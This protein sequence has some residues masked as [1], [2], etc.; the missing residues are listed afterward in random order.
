MAESSGSRRRPGPGKAFIDNSIK[1][2]LANFYRFQLVNPSSSSQEYE[3][4]PAKFDNIKLSFLLWAKTVPPNGLPIKISESANLT[5]RRTLDLLKNEDRLEEEFGL[6]KTYGDITRKGENCLGRGFRYSYFT[7]LIDFLPIYSASTWAIEQEAS[8]LTFLQLLRELVDDLRR[9]TG[10]EWELHMQKTYAANVVSGMTI[11]ELELA[12]RSGMD[13]GDIVANTASQKL[14]RHS[15]EPTSLIAQ[16]D[17]VIEATYSEDPHTRRGSE[18]DGFSES[19]ASEAVMTPS[20][21]ATGLSVADRFATLVERSFESYGD[22]LTLTNTISHFAKRRILTELRRFRHAP[23][24]TSLSLIGS[25]LTDLLG[26]FVGPPET[27]Y[28]GGIFFVQFNIPD[29]YPMEPPSCRMLTKTYHPNIDSNGVIC[30]NIF[31]IGKWQPVWSLW[32]LLLAITSVLENPNE[33]DSSGSEVAY[34]YQEN[35]REFNKVAQSWTEKFATGE[36]PPDW[37][38]QRPFPSNKPLWP[39]NAKSL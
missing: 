14:G 20:L 2:C 39:V 15:G 5:M 31:G 21:S 3:V 24:L 23:P 1:H 35:H 6:H 16:I 37:V 38:L 18:V 19:L 17:E 30:L 25:S 32:D 9:S 33:K 12:A 4:L 34:L 28:E 10:S 36:W 11:S 13:D 26:I 8:F 7:F 22:L 29:G 27:P